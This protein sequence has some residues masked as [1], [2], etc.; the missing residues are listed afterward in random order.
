MKN[1]E[2]EMI[3]CGSHLNPNGSDLRCGQ[4]VFSPLSGC[5]EM[6]L[7][8]TCMLKRKINGYQDAFDRLSNNGEKK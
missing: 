7:C 8:S 6:E 4:K 3:G 5:S 1:E 2:R